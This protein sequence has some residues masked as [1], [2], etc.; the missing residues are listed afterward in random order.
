MLKNKDKIYAIELKYK[1]RKIDIKYNGEEFHLR[2][3]G[4]QPL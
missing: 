2:D 1:T 3:Q 4:A